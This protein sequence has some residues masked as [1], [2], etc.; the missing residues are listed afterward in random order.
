MP[1][2]RHR[3]RQHSI[4]LYHSSLEIQKLLHTMK[5]T[6]DLI[7]LIQH[8][9]T[10]SSITKKKLTVL[11]L[12]NMACAAVLTHIP[13]TSDDTALP[14]RDSTDFHEIQF[15]EHFRFRKQDFYR[16]LCALKLTVSPNDPTPQ[17]LHIGTTGTQSAVPSDWAMMVLLKRLSHA[18]QYRYVSALP[19]VPIHF[20]IHN[21]Q[22]PH[23]TYTALK[24]THP[25]TNKHHTATSNVCSEVPKHCSQRHSYTCCKPS[26]QTTKRGCLT[27]H[28]LRISW[29][30]ASTC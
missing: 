16:L 18:S 10:L 28:S 19:A 6:A 29:A 27:S 23:H 8:L 2:H 11:L 9:P 17:I 13:R 12:L 21:R 1:T 22:R 30:H 24:H 7:R 20:T 5:N 15:K 14:R 3:P 4:R 25:N 26:T